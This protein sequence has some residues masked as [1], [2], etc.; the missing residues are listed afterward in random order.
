MCSFACACF[1][2][3]RA[4]WHRRQDPEDFDFME[5]NPTHGL[6]AAAGFSGGGRI[7]LVLPQM[8]LR[9]LP[10][11]ESPSTVPAIHPTIQITSGENRA[12]EAA[13]FSFREARAILGDLFV[14]KPWIYWTDLIATATIGYVFAAIFLYTPAFTLLSTL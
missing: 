5:A 6:D 14:H 4:E 9:A 2:T 1:P 12:S 7:P 13:S 3:S 11:A 8:T 10:A